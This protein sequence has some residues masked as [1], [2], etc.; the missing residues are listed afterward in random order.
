MQIVCVSR[1]TLSGGREL[2][3][4]A[5]EK[6]GY[7]CLSREELNDAATDAGIQ[8]GKLEMA[9]VR[10]GIFSERLALERDHYLAFTTEYLC[11]KAEN[12]GL[13][14]HGRTG[15]FLL[16]GVSHVLRARVVADEEY[17]IRS[18]MRDLRL[19]RSKAQRYIEEV[20]E[21]R[22]RW[23]HSMYGVAWQDA[24]NY[25]VVLNLAQVSVEN[26][27]TM[28]VQMAQL[29]DFQPTPASTR[30][31]QDLHLAASARLRIA[32][33]ERTYKAR[34]KVRADSGVV[35]AIYLPQDAR[36]ADAIVQ[37]CRGLP[38]AREFRATMAAANLLWIQEEFPP[39]AELMD[40][41][42]QIAT[43]WN[44]AVELVKPTS[45]DGP[46]DQADSDLGEGVT[47]A[48]VDAGQREYDGGIEDDTPP[49]QP[50]R[51][52][53]ESTLNELAK[54]GRSGGG[55]VITGSP[56]DVLNAIDLSTPYT[57]VVI[58]DV[59]LSKGHSARVR[60]TRDLRGFLSDRMRAPVVTAEDL[61]RH[62]LFGPRDLA[63][64]SV[65]LMLTIVLF[66]LIFTYQEPVMAFTAHAGWYAEAVENSF[67]SKVP[68]VPK[69]IVSV[70]VFLLVPIVA[71]SYGTVTKSLLKLIRME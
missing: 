65:L 11:A 43:K 29:P 18:V 4:R 48:A 49:T 30:S 27:A 31:M 14:Y 7:G 46:V 55:R 64:A 69:A 42:V 38:G 45:D 15:H 12:G 13:V 28:L 40:Q 10:P 36:L 56:Q 39:P 54:L 1:G 33:D 52:G 53:L 58:G 24:G 32:Q 37:V 21:D 70:A 17:R 68:W 34:V 63:K 41:V 47:E 51:E 19:P 2:A 50:D 16:L 57:L 71:Y 8:V 9:M 61:G 23:V 5:A 3:S 26:A 25:D 22:R 66:V 44:A 67:L 62:Y 59:F 35:N 6:L 20:D 60:A